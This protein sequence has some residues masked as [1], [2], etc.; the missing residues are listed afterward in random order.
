[1]KKILVI[2]E[3]RLM[4]VKLSNRCGGNFSAIFQKTNVLTHN[5]VIM[6][7]F[8]VGVRGFIGA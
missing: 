2:S 4:R 1:M 7:S 8:A 6:Q 3:I 5:L